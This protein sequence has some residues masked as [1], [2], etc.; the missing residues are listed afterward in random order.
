MKKKLA[1]LFNEPLFLL[2]ALLLLYYIWT[3]FNGKTSNQELLDCYDKA[4]NEW[5]RHEC[6]ILYYEQSQ[7]NDVGQ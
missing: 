2:P 1:N 3:C 6:N 4:N 7:N 5:D